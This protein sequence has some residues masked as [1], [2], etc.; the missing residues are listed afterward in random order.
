MVFYNTIMIV[1]T[2]IDKAG[3]VIIPKAVRDELRLEAGDSVEIELRDGAMHLCSVK[4]KPRMVKEQGIWVF[5]GGGTLTT[6]DILQQIKTGRDERDRR[7]M[8]PEK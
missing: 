4:E 5:N 2:T 6:E 7:N 1:T 3:R 8:Y